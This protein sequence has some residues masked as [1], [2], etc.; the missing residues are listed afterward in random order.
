M[1]FLA[2]LGA[3][4]LSVLAFE[5]WPDCLSS[6]HPSLWR[7]PPDELQLPAAH[8]AAI[9]MGGVAGGGPAAALIPGRRRT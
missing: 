3:L 4:S 9:H 7:Q 2:F 1:T 8:P 6:R 5:P